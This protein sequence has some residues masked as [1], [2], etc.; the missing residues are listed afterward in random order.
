MHE[1]SLCE[2]L[3]ELILEE[4]LKAGA[5]QVQEVRLRVGKF[6]HVDPEALRFCFS[7]VMMDSPAREAT[8]TIL[9]SQTRAHCPECGNTCSP[10]ERY[11][12]CPHCGAFGLLFDEGGEL[13]LESLIVQ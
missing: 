5:S 12:P 8:L 10:E 7:S 9:E 1:L 3:R 4:T 2:A 6:S 13:Q 11:S